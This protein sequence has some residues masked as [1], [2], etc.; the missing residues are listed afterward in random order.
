MYM[1]ITSTGKSLN[2]LR[3]LLD[4]TKQTT[5]LINFPEK[6]PLLKPS[7]NKYFQRVTPESC[8]I[9]SQLVIDF[10]NELYNS[11]TVGLQNITLMRK[12]RIFFEADIGI[13]NSA[14]CKATFSEAKTVVALAVGMLVTQGK[15]K[16][17]EK[18]CDIFAD[19]ITPVLKLRLK[20]LTVKHLL[21]M[22]SGIT[23]NEL[24]CMTS[25]DWIKSYLNSDISGTIG[26]TFR[27]N[28]LNS[29]MLS[30]IICK[31][32]G[33]SLSDYL[34]STLFKILE[35]TDFYWEKCP[36]GIEKGGWGLYLHREDLLKLGL[37]VMQNGFWK[38]KKII[39]S[40]YVMDMTST[41]TE[42]PLD[43]GDYNYGFH[44]WCGRND[45]KFLFNGMLGQNLIGYR[46]NEI[47]INANCGNCDIF[48]QN[49]FFDICDKYFGKDFKTS[50]QDNDKQKDIESI[51]QKLKKPKKPISFL[52]SS[53]IT[54]NLEQDLKA[55]HQKEFYVNSQ[56]AVS[57]G[58]APLLMQCIQCN[59]ASGLEK[60]L[61]RKKENTLEMVFFETNEIHNI[62]VGFENAIINNVEIGGN[63]FV[64]AAKGVFCENEFNTPILKIQCEFL[65]TPFSRT[66][67]FYLEEN[68]YYAVFKEQPANMVTENLQ[69][70]S[71]FVSMGG[72]ITESIFS[73]LDS[74]YIIAKLRKSFS[75]TLILKNK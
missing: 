45:N 29:Y 22:T 61:F 69:R 54:R 73:K 27:Y 41:K 12:D 26:K 47:I 7:E 32:T 18:I 3:N 60:I 9:D 57:L 33:M 59:Y 10:I 66:F 38:G 1:N 2:L 6:K 20:N 17:S 50:L 65:E 51:K 58:F 48:Q 28:S 5:A 34:A 30:A 53:I 46:T 74:D 67:I 24:E 11:K 68:N 15:L 25:S 39:A 13:Q 36:N 21:T 14:Y 71:E 8:G 16:L 35:I 70:L 62:E 43:Y 52:E 75:P 64:V 63:F 4:T 49:E 23:F 37:L 40:K 55:I 72:Q 31:R 42:T 56:N 44:T 19:K